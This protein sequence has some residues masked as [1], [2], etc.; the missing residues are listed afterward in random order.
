MGMLGKRSR[1]GRSTAAQGK[2]KRSRKAMVPRGVRNLPTIAFKRTWYYGVFQPT[3]AT[4]AGFWQ[5]FT[6]QFSNMPNATEYTNLFDQY[7]INGIKWTFRPR[8]DSFAGNDTTDTTL[9]GVT[10]QQGVNL[11]I[12]KDPMS[13][14]TPTGTYSAGTLNNYL[15]NGTVR[16]YTGTKP[17]TVYWKP[18][19]DDQLSTGTRRVKAPFISS[20]NSTVSH[21]GFHAFFQDFNFSGSFGQNWDMFVTLYFQCRGQR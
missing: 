16:S 4:T 20:S 8:F 14:V 15:E 13:T 1:G 9:P 5:Y 3:T 2:K 12:I 19:I 11:H 21:A 18:M 10:N 17:V 6:I 7:R